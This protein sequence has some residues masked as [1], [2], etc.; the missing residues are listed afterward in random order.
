[1]GQKK[2]LT[3]VKVGGKILE[4]E[5]TLAAL[6]ERFAKIEGAKVLVHGGGRSATQ[7]AGKLGVETKM[8]DGRRVTD[9][10]MLKIVTMVYGGLINKTV[11]AR[12]QALM[13]NALGM[14]GADL[15]IIRSH[16]RPV[17]DVDYGWVGDV[18]KVDGEM[19]AALIEKGVV[20]IVAP[21]THD[22]EGHMLNTNADTMAGEIALGL[23]PYYDVELVFC[24]EKPGVL[25]DEND[26]ESVVPVID[27]GSFEAL[28]SEGV[29][30]GGMIPKV[31][32]SLKS[33]EKGVKKVIITKSSYL[34]DYAKGTKII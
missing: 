34:G 20:P 23:V 24:F 25:R 13:V 10:E 18:D 17:K 28:K 4:G 6:L 27:R 19:L 12:L 7:L 22:G 1:M 21:L 31:E 32:N 26:D 29:I 15:N 16:R 9:D 2:K 8:I 14:T 3:V 11:V 33:I 5:S 30:T